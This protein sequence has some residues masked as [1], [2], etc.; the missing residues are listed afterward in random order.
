MSLFRNSRGAVEVPAGSGLAP[1]IRLLA[2]G[3]N[4]WSDAGRRSIGSFIWLLPR[5]SVCTLSW[6]LRGDDLK[7]R[8]RKVS[9]SVVSIFIEVS[10]VGSSRRVSITSPG[11]A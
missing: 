1:H 8:A 9:I 2:S 6:V 10:R 7:K 11:S 5:S 4:P 3:G